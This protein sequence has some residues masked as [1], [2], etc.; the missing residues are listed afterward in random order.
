MVINFDRES[1]CIGDDCNSHSENKFIQDSMLVSDLLLSL[2]NYVP[3]IED[4][5][6]VIVSLD[7]SNK[8][9]GFIVTDKRRKNKIELN[10]V[11]TQIKNIFSKKDDAVSIVCRYYYTTKFSPTEFDEYASSTCIREFTLLEKVKLKL[12]CETTIITTPTCKR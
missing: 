1:V 3:I 7:A 6:W 2:T 12:Q 5:V 11:D 4:T 10:V 9:I 8:V